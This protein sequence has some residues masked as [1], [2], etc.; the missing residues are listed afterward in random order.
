[1]PIVI[2]GLIAGSVAAMSV[3]VSAA[4]Y[5][6]AKTRA[7][8]EGDGAKRNPDRARKTRSV[9]PMERQEGTPEHDP[10][11]PMIERANVSPSR[12]TY[13]GLLAYCYDFLLHSNGTVIFYP[14]GIS[15]EVAQFY[16]SVLRQARIITD[17]TNGHCEW[18]VQRRITGI[19]DVG[20]RIS[21]QA[22]DR[23]VSL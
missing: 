7:L 20:V 15:S 8:Y 23:L 17:G 12:V 16:L 11:Q 6:I 2:A 19:D 3:A 13:D 21:R 14:T 9:I 10:G 5:F 18:A 4:Y 1:V 22:F